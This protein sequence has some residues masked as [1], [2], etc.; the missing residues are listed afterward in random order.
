MA[1]YDYDLVVLGGG[2]AGLTTV[3]GAAQ[4]GARTLLVEKENAL[5]GDCLHY[6]CVPSKTLIK[7]A[8][9][10]WQMKHCN[11]FGLPEVELPPVDFSKLP[12]VSGRL[13]PPFSIMIPWS[14]SRVSVPR[15]FLRSRNSLMSTP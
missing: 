4:L 2:A 6:G 9:V 11:R 12:V 3:S 8:A 10:Y 7:S 14:D 5:G 15:W 13:Y 1:K